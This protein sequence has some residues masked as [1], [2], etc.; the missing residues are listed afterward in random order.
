MEWK[1]DVR[2]EVFLEL[3]FNLNFNVYGNFLFII[4]VD[5]L[6]GFEGVLGFGVLCK[7]LQLLE[8]ENLVIS[9]FLLKVI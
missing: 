5:F 7:N 8:N 1:R 2:L 6:G 3:E 9:V 4:V